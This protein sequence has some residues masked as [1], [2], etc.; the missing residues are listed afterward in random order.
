MLIKKL[1]QTAAAILLAASL[2]P[3]W[4]DAPG[5]QPKSREEIA[6]S[7]KFQDG[8]IDL[9]NGIAT[10]DLPPSFR[11]L[12]P[13]DTK[14]VLEDLWHNPPGTGD[15]TLG[16]IFPASMSYGV[17]V[18]YREE[19]HVNDDDA[20]KINYA[21][22]L[23]QMKEDTEE[24][25][26]ERVKQGYPSMLLSGWAEDPHYD[27]TTH[28]LYWA[29][30][31]ATP[32]SEHTLNYKIRVL[33]RKGVLELNAIAGMSQIAEIKTE[34][35]KVIAFTEFKPG[36]AYADFNSNTDHVAEY[37]IAALVAGAAAAKLGLF[38]KIALWLAP[39]WKLLLAGWKLV[40]VA[41]VGLFAGIGKLLG[42]KKKDNP[43]GE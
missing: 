7:L 42:M 32:A 29:L 22:L 30:D 35:Q 11:Y 10:L 14:K 17:V 21:D 37:G 43:S 25:S 34:M 4:A 2:M 40:L 3:A 24:E 38:A 1:F 33:G 5:S 13:A 27:Q 6:A 26:K 16:M 18:T 41:V 9:P 15:N 31:L 39:L 12:G 28:K 20:S 23:K 19:G 8:K 36:N